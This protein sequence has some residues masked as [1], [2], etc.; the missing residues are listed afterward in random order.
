M[1]EPSRCFQRTLTAHITA[2]YDRA[3][4]EPDEEVAILNVLLV[5]KQWPAFL[6]TT[7]TIGAKGFRSTGFHQLSATY[8]VPLLALTLS[9][10]SGT[11]PTVKRRPRAFP[12]PRLRRKPTP[13]AT[14]ARREG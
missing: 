13:P 10:Q 6:G 2:S 5:K 7:S 4:F 11:R 3:P 12:C 14:P 1:R 8:C 9:T